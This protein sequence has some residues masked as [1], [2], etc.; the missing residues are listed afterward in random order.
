MKKYLTYTICCVI[1]CACESIYRKVILMKNELK[2]LLSLF[3]AVMLIM[4]CGVLSVFAA[5]APASVER[6]TTIPTVYVQGYGEN[7][8]S[9]KNDKNS[10]ILVGGNVPF[11][12]DGV[13]GGMLENIMEPLMKGVTTG[14]YT[15]YNDL[16]VNTLVAD[17][18]RFGLDENGEPS[19]GSGNDCVRETS[20]TNKRWYGGKYD[21]YA[22]SLKY[23][24]RVDV[25]VT[26]AE[27][28]AY[29]QKVKTA[30]GSSKVNLVGRCLGANVVL[31]YLS[32][33]GYDDV[34]AVNFYVGGIDGFE[35]VGAL[36]SG[37]VVV[38]SDALDRFLQMTLDS[39]EDELISFAKSFVA[40]LNFINGLD[41]PIDV[42]YSIYDQVYTDIIPRI[43]KE[44]FG[45]MP[46][47]WSFVGDDYFEAAKEL[48]FP[49][50]EEQTKYAKLIEKIDRYY[51]EVTLKTEDIINGAIDA[52]VCV[53]F[54]AKYGFAA[55]PISEE[56]NLHSDNTVS[57][58]SQTYG[59]TTTEMGKTFSKDY[60]ANAE[61]NGTAKYIS[62][63]KCI[64]ASTGIL[65]D[66]TWF[67]K[68][69]KHAYMPNCIDIMMAQIF[70][71][72][73]LENKYVTVNDIES[74]PQYLYVENLDE[75]APLNIMTEDT[76]DIGNDWDVGI[77]E[78][79]SNFLE[80]LFNF[81]SSFVNQILDLIANTEI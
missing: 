62:P 54:T 13:L 47:F 34:N 76:A 30:T 16:I 28:D 81:V 31:A 32:E 42:I 8:Y 4:S 29:I 35:I 5:E 2:K 17:L 52:G 79:L 77:F 26:A 22:Y 38:D 6:A 70:E 18:G 68:G 75:Y 25:F 46:A 43:L 23:D 64:D 24:W 19:D 15:E 69:S 66:H 67:I 12:T 71:A 11:L 48:N 56:A 36:F 63:D 44:S 61:N 65:P 50:E 3:L 40:I 45:T 41:L 78:H 72:T 39:E 37:Q 10:E 51:N 9:D 14:D 55:V 7:I 1:I 57:V 59:A 49:T 53:Y 27:L 33:Y 74:Y 73:Y 20:V 80:K 60:L 21:I 58:T